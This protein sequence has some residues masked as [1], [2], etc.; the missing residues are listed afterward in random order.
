ML[1]ETESEEEEWEEIHKHYKYAS[2]WSMFYKAVPLWQVKKLVNLFKTWELSEC[3]G[4]KDIRS[5]VE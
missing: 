1:S 3:F 2:K 5:H 4:S